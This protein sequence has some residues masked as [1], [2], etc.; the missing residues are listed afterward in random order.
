MRTARE[1]GDA[2][3]TL[4]DWTK[5]LSGLGGGEAQLYWQQKAVCREC[6]WYHC[7]VTGNFVRRSFE[8]AGKGLMSYLHD[9]ADRPEVVEMFPP[10]VAGLELPRE[11]LEKLDSPDQNLSIASVELKSLEAPTCDAG[12]SM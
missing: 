11:Q 4:L 9:Y 8:E 2:W 6:I 10:T 1:T 12:G 7:V 5:C 3:P